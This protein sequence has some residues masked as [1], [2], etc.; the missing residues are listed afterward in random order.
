MFIALDY[1]D[2]SGDDDSVADENFE[3][4][5]E[6]SEESDEVNDNVIKGKVLCLTVLLDLIFAS[7]Y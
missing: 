1:T 2:S 5:D 4:S 6:S 3:P 7:L